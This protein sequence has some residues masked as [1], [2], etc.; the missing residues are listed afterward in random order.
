MLPLVS[1]LHYEKKMSV[2]SRR[3]IRDGD[4]VIIDNI[5]VIEDHEMRFASNPALV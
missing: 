5:L 3:D 4:R 1:E 2:K